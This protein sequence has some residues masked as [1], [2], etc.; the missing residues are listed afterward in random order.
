MLGLISGLV[1][2]AA[3]PHPRSVARVPTETGTQ[4]PVA[5]TP[6][7]A[8]DGFS[9][10]VGAK[11]A[12]GIGALTGAGR[13][14]GEG[15]SLLQI[16]DAGLSDI[17]DALIRMKELATEADTTSYS[18]GE[19]AIMNAEFD[20]LRT[21]IDSIVDR[22][23]F[24]DSKVLE[25]TSLAF[26]VGTGNASQDSITL[27]I[28]AATVAGLDAGL[29][30]D[31]IDNVSNASQALTD[32]TNAI[33]VLS[34]IQ[35]STDGAAVRFDGVQR[36]VTLDKNTLSALRTDLL[37]R[38]VTVGTAGQLASL[39][40]QEYLSRAAPVAAGRLSSAE[41]ALLSTS[42][43]RSTEP[44]QANDRTPS[45]DEAQPKAVR[46]PSPYETV[47]YNKPSS[48]GETSHSVDIEA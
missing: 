13:N 6:L 39:V 17:S 37:V 16:A 26:K 15:A 12:V 11:E 8:N 9:V 45:R 42:Q 30:S 7:R 4:I 10:A 29:T 36:L 47:Q 21:E 20:Q 41:R 28:A 48:R 2:P 24:N 31:S 1:A 33:D 25:G 14:A 22:T 18:R 3:A 43:L 35:S 34:G 38:P 19:R 5:R 40:S 27:S 46:R 32:V 23:K 44:P